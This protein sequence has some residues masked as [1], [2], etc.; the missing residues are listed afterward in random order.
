MSNETLNF[1]N[2]TTQQKLDRFIE[3]WHKVF[4]ESDESPEATIRKYFTD[5]YQFHVNGQLLN[6]EDMVSRARKMREYIDHAKLT[7]IESVGEGNKLAEIHEV[8]VT[9]IDGARS[10][11]RLHNFLEFS[12]DKIKTVRS[13]TM[14]FDGDERHDDIA[15][16]H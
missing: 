2:A 4:V 10:T 5:D 14:N 16:R 15:S 13:L 11:V 12:G 9:T 3:M 8:D 7:V 1:E 6:F